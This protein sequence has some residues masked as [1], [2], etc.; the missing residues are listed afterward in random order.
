[1]GGVGLVGCGPALLVRLVLAPIVGYVVARHPRQFRSALGAVFATLEDE[2]ERNFSSQVSPAERQ[3]FRAAR[4]RFHDA[5]NAGRIDMTTADSLRRRL[6]QESRKE[7]M[8][9]EDV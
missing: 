2:V 5:W 1:M 9:P 8:T 4:A 7:R 3:E 6:M